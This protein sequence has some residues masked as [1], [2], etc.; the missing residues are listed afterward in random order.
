MKFQDIPQFTK[1]APYVVDVPWAMLE[2][3]LERYND[4]GVLQLDP[5]F[6]RAHVWTVDQ[7]RRYVEYVLRGGKSSRDVYFNQADWMKAY[8]KPMYLVD[9][10]QRLEA[11]RAFLRNDL[12]IL[13]GVAPYNYPL[14]IKLH[15]FEDRLSWDESFKFHINDLPT[16]AQVLQWYIDLNAGGVAHTADEIAKVR[17]L[18]KQEQLKE[19]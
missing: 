9:G 15:Q 1:S 14:G 6:Q 16:Y 8:Q 4:G 7:Q 13:V 3:H 2:D 5:E 17:D 18:L 11:V 10:K 12:A 19:D